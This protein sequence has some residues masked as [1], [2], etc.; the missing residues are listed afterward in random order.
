MKTVIIYH[1]F[2]GVT[3][4]VAERVRDA[5]GGDLLEVRPRQAYSRLTAYTLG[6]VRARGGH[7]DP[8]EPPSIDV[9]TY[10]RIV[11]G[12]PVWA[13]RAT[14]V[15][16]SAVDGLR[17]AAGKSAVLFATCGAQAGETFPTL[18]SALEGEGVRVIGEFSFTKREVGDAGKIAAL[19]A[20]VT[21][22][23]VS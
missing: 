12:T 1:S 13:G 7:R 3:R 22:P 9:S 16:N 6:I 14:P 11:L 20:A 23:D 21:A 8:I 19:N 15:M 2:S 17:G 18:R 10:D 5:C 4:G